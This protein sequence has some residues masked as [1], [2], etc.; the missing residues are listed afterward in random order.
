[1]PI[2]AFQP[3]GPSALVAASSSTS[4]VS[5]TQ[6]CTGSQQGMYLA[7]PSTIAV[8]VAAGSSS[9]QA[10]CPT[11]S[12]PAVGQCIPAGTQEHI[13]SPPAG[14]LSAVTSGGSA[15]LFATPGQYGT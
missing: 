8:Y 1:M 13:W 4:G 10:A 9:V 2:T 12:V 7:N 5:P 14:W 3:M 11:T 6:V 15:S